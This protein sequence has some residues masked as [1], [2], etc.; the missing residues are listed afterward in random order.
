M[1]VSRST[2]RKWCAG[3]PTLR[4]IVAL[5]IAMDLRADIGEELVRIASV[6]YRN[7]M[8]Q[9]ILLAMLF[10]TKDLTVVRANEVM[11]QSDLP[12]LTQGEEETE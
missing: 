2:A 9:T 6:P 12:P 10:D 3:N 1:G 7:S 8:E 5:C 4:H 11:K